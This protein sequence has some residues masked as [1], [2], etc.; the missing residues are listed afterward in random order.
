MPKQFLDGKDNIQYETNILRSI[1]ITRAICKMFTLNQSKSL[2][3]TNLKEG[4]PDN[5]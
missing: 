2:S 1:E 4:N 5:L 3:Y